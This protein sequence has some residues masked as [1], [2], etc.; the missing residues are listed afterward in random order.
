MKNK[1]LTWVLLLFSLVFSET[2]IVHKITI[3]GVI[4]PVASEY[5]M[6]AIERAEAAGAEMIIIEMDT[7]G[8]LMVSMHDI[9]KKI[10][11]ADVPVAVYVSPPGS[12]AGSA[13]VFITMAAHVAAMAPGTNIGSAHPV[14]M[15]GSQD[16]SQ[17][18][19]E[20]IINDAVAHIRS[21]S[22]K[23]GRNA[24]W[25]E[26]AV[27]ESANI[28]AKEALRLHVVDY[29]VTT[30]DSLL[31]VV[32]GREVEV[33]SGKR[34]LDTRN[35]RIESFE[36]NW[37]QRALDMLSDP[38]ILYILFLVGI[39]GISLELYNPGA[40]LPGVVGGI[41]IILFL[42]AVQTIPVNLAGILLILFAA[43]LFL[44]EIKVASYGMLS[45]GGVVSLV[46]G[47]LMLI[48]SPLP[49]LQ[50]SWKL[51]FAATL[52]FTLFFLFAAGFAIRTLRTKPTT[53][54]EGMIGE[55]GVALE[56]LAPTGQVQIHGEIW[57]ATS[58]N[59]IKKG[60]RVAVESVDKHHLLLKVREVE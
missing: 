37:R 56:N 24:D 25:A 58:Q 45:I 30:A 17:V 39:S 42:Y 15:S 40:I 4:N 13:G 53:G 6:E 47:S 8:G 31:S 5:I 14:N 19:G 20:K 10:L 23:R 38:N 41:S 48:D 34:I 32:D 55:Q 35:A 16:T 43:V 2:K 21:V 29:I 50:I 26:S 18:M 59:K 27:R 52:S 12:R 1:I 36:M 54:K 49:F 9:V 33:L 22:A 44:L 7:P 3:N 51:I 28:T 60:Q 46:L 11:G 57:K